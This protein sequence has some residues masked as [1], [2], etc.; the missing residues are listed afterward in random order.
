MNEAYSLMDAAATPQDSQ[1]VSGVSGGAAHPMR[2]QTLWAMA[3][4]VPLTSSSAHAEQQWAGLFPQSS[5]LHN[6]PPD[7]RPVVAKP[8]TQILPATATQLAAVQG[9]F[10]LAKTQLALV[11]GVQRQTIYDWYAGK[12][13]AEE[14]NARRLARLYTLVSRLRESGLAPLTGRLASRALNTGKTL[15]DVLGENEIDERE[16]TALVA[17]LGQAGKQQK[18]RGAA[19][20][21]ERLGWAAQSRE[22]ADRT[23]EDNLEDVVDG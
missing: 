15:L 21:R 17:Q 7:V 18:A 11:C 1:A 5:T 3:L 23:R 14:E 13:E 20:V 10:G 22:A 8:V 6:E 4:T 2:R 9:F 19:A 16:V 12:F